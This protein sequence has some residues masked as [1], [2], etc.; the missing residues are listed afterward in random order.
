MHFLNLEVRSHAFL[1]IDFVS[2]IRII[3]FASNGSLWMICSCGFHEVTLQ[4]FVHGRL[5]VI[6]AILFFENVEAR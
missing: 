2:M 6:L 1:S 4:F 5:L 3:S